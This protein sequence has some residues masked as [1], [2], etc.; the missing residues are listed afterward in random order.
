[1]LKRLLYILLLIP[2]MFFSQ[3]TFDEIEEQEPM[4]ADKVF[5]DS[6][7]YN[8]SLAFEKQRNF[9]VD[10][11]EE[12]SGS[13]FKY[14]ED[15]V[16]KKNFEPKKNPNLSFLKIFADF[17]KTIFPFLLAAIIIFIILK[18]YL[19]ESINLWNFNK[20]KNKLAEKLIYEDEDIESTDLDSL[21]KRAL[22]NKNTRLATRY[23]YLLVLKKLSQKEIIKYDKD[24]TN[25]EYLFELEDVGI[26]KDFS[27]L[28]Y[29][30]SYVWYGEFN[31]NENDFNKVQK[32]YKSF[33]K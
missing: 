21:L 29:I 1:M 4:E 12:Y 22:E 23:Y 19:G 8:K 2:F 24:K 9:T 30:Y 25:S 3:E 16:N 5:K 31:L 32:R 20:P 13:E 15:K 7:A 28:S 26:R 17:M 33:L 18:L 14:K 6:I 27:Y 10:I 11:N